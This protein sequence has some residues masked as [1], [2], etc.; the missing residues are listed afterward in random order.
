MAINKGRKLTRTERRAEPMMRIVKT[1]N[2]E[3]SNRTSELLKEP[4]RRRQM[5]VD[6]RIRSSV[7]RSTDDRSVSCKAK[8]LSRSESKRQIR[9]RIRGQDNLDRL[10]SKSLKRSARR[11]VRDQAK[12]IYD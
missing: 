8:S 7:G 3:L 1:S 10:E 5:K 2:S 6:D 4:V 11:N 12:K 9:R